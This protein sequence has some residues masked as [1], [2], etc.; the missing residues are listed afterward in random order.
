M[1][2]LKNLYYAVPDRLGPTE[3]TRSKIRSVLDRGFFDGREDRP[4]KAIAF[5]HIEAIISKRREKS[6]NEITGRHEGGIEAAKKLRK[7]LVRL[8]DFAIKVGLIEK[9]PMLGVD[10]VKV[11]PSERSKGFHAWTDE[12]IEQYRLRHPLGSRARL[13][14]ELLLWTGQR[15]VDSSTLGIHHVKNGHFEVEQ[16]KT[17]KKL[18][19][20]I[21]PQ[22]LEAILASPPPN[23]SPCFLVSE[24]GKPYSQKG[25]GNRFRDWCDQAGL[26]HC[27]AHG[28]RKATLRRMAEL[29]LSNKTMKAVSG[30]VKDDELNRYI[31]E[32]DQKRLAQQG[33]RSLSDWEAAPKDN[34]AG[35][36]SETIALALERWLSE[37]Q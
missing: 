30:H 1:G 32:A 24:H 33:I 12:E 25:F 31:K 15:S 8:F 6:V 2:H 21:A 27:T 18:V 20:P 28:L 23:G 11:A 19:L 7:E 34:N 13:A 9:S 5:H 22:L 35:D 29:R 17:G 4:I 14:L 26:H 16:R 36:G 3:T 37:K 10:R